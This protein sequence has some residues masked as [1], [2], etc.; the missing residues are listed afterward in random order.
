MQGQ[1]PHGGPNPLMAHPPP[2]NRPGSSGMMSQ[3]RSSQGPPP[4]AAPSRP[5][6]GISLGRLF[7]RDQLAVPMVVYQ[8]ISAIDLYGLS[9]E[10]IYRLSGS[11]PHV[12]KLK[13]MFDTGM[14]RVETWRVSRL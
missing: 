5:V 10:G 4:Q 11:V 6:F 3:G 13:G 7:D 2:T 8:C 1:P 14:C 12:N 9:V